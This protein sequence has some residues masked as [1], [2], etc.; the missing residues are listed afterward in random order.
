MPTAPAA[1]H[2]MSTSRRSSQSLQSTYTI[3]SKKSPG[4]SSHMVPSSARAST[5]RMAA[6]TE[7]TSSSTATTSLAVICW[8]TLAGRVNIRYPSSP[9]RF[10]NDGTYPD[11]AADVAFIRNT[12]AKFIDSR[13]A[14]KGARSR[15][16]WGGGVRRLNMGCCAA[17]PAACGCMGAKGGGCMPAKGAACGGHGKKPPAE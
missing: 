16:G 3:M 14:L 12:G 5:A 4:R 10:L 15:A 9:S 1:R 13:S 7:S 6:A 2:R 11:K 8:D 17:A